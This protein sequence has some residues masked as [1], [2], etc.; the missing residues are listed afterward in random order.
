MYNYGP[1]IEMILT[2]TAFHTVRQQWNVLSVQEAEWIQQ[3]IKKTT[4]QHVK[5]SGEAGLNLPTY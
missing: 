1:V 2:F 4:Y 5:S 3:Y